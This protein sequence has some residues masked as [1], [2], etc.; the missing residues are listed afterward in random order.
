[1]RKLL[2]LVAAM[3][4]LATSCL[5]APT[6]A[7]AGTKYDATQDARIVSLESIILGPNGLQTLVGALNTKV[8]S[9]SSDA[10]LSSRVSSLETRLATAESK[11][12]TGGT[13]SATTDAL[14]ARI[15]TLEDWKA[16]LPT[17]SSGTGGTSAVPVTGQVTYNLY[18]EPDLVY[19]P[20]SYVWYLEIMN[21]T[22]EYKKVYVSGIMNTVDTHLADVVTTAGTGTR[23]N[24]PDLTGGTSDTTG[25]FSMNFV[26]TNGVDA[27]MVSGMSTGY[28]IIKGGEKKLVAIMLTLTYTGPDV[29]RWETIWSINAQKYP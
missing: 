23:F 28:V 21:G 6:S 10:G 14:S 4:L 19:T 5:N 7:T 8:A 3:S 2:V 22:S 24:S 9:F 18:K 17:G 12:A 1:M 20:G 26:P 29:S 27:T 15:K 25:L 11:L 16:A 13:S